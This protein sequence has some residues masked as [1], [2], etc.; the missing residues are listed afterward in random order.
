[1]R[2]TA[3]FLEEPR[4]RKTGAEYYTEPCNRCGHTRAAHTIGSTPSQCRE[5][6]RKGG[7]L[8]GCASFQEEHP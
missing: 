2:Q 6:T 8:C 5:R 3:L 7:P 4:R 1:M